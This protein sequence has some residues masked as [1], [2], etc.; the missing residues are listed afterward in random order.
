VPATFPVW[1]PDSRTIM[2]TSGEERLWVTRSDGTGWRATPLE[3]GI[4]AW[5]APRR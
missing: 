5:I 3:G 2:F 4:A 1:S